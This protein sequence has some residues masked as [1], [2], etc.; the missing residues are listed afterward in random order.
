MSSFGF[1]GNLARFFARFSRKQVHD[2]EG[3]ITAIVRLESLVESYGKTIQGLEATIAS[4][5]KNNAADI[6]LS[7]SGN[8]TGHAL[9]MNSFYADRVPHSAAD[10]E[11]WD[12]SNL[13][14]LHECFKDRE[15]HRFYDLAMALIACTHNGDYYEFGCCGAG[16]MRMA[17][18]KAKKW[19][20]NSMDFYAFDSFQGM[21]ADGSLAMTEELFLASVRNDGVEGHKVTTFPGFYDKS[22][23]KELQE[24]FL[25]KPRSPMLINVDCDLHESA[26]CVFDFIAPLVRTGTILYIDDFWETLG[27]GRSFGTALAF[28]EFCEKHKRLK[29]HPFVPVGYWG[30]SFVACDAELFT[31]P[32]V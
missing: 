16:S 5:L 2:L 31:G 17:L 13:A 4:L 29:F 27:R 25:K 26:Q 7:V 24:E 19:H 15:W 30:M 1:S 12:E 9:E 32:V 23:T 6:S 20:L 21:P 22:L 8:L 28:N 11:S 3:A 14:R 18:S 10:F